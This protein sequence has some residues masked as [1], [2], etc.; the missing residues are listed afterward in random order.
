MKRTQKERFEQGGWKIGTASELLGLTEAE[1]AGLIRKWSVRAPAARLARGV[2]GKG[3]RRGP[4]RGSETRAPRGSPG[5]RP[6]RG[7]HTRRAAHLQ[8]RCDFGGSKPLALGLQWS[9]AGST[10]CAVGPQ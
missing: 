4:R 2:T 8:F 1:E 5:A 3:T 6:A 10:V 9:P 7:A